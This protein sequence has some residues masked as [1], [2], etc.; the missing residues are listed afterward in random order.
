MLVLDLLPDHLAQGIEVLHR[1]PPERHGRIALRVV[2]ALPIEVRLDPSDEVGDLRPLVLGF[3]EQEPQELLP[4][5][6]PHRPVVRRHPPRTPLDLRHRLIARVRPHRRP[7]PHALERSHVESEPTVVLAIGLLELGVGRIEPHEVL[8]LHVEHD[9]LGV[10][11]VPPEHVR[12]EQG[13]EEEQ[14]VGRLGRDAGDAGDVHVGAAGP[15]EEVEV[16]EHRLA[17]PGQACRE[18]P[19]HL[20]EV[21]GLVPVLAPGPGRGQAWHGRDEHL[22]L[23]PGGHDLG[24]DRRVDRQ[25]AALNEEHVRVELRS[26]VP[27]PDVLD[28]AGDPKRT[29]PRDLRVDYAGVVAL[30]VGIGGDAHPENERGGVLGTQD[31]ADRLADVLHHAQAASSA[32]RA[33]RAR[34][35][36]P[37]WPNRC[38]RNR[39]SPA[40]GARFWGN[41][42][43]KGRPANPGSRAL[44]R[45]ARL[46]A[47]PRPLATRTPQPTRPAWSCHSGRL[48]TRRVYH[49]YRSSG[50]PS[51]TSPNSGV[52]SP[53]ESRGRSASS[54]GSRY[55]RT[56]RFTTPTTGLRVASRNP[57]RPSV[58]TSSSL[59]AAMREASAASCAIIA[60]CRP[61]SGA[62]GSPPGSVAGWYTRTAPPTRTSTRRTPSTNHTVPGSTP[63]ETMGTLHSS[64]STK[65]S[66]LAGVSS[67]RA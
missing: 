58:S 32:R 28:D 48:R 17:V 43:S 37:R 29:P 45:S 67:S 27:G 31:P 26:L 7:H 5:E 16:E 47:P 44:T 15:V 3:G 40:I 57:R 56:N 2:G 61:N 62:S 49:A 35:I 53:G 36:S 13:V 11:R 21:Q 39:S 66:A 60:F 1:V 6:L 64:V 55:A 46:L 18:P 63:R 33:I 25:H 4:D 30:E 12:V 10:G 20:V 9:G 23:E 42:G 38:R 59:P 22:G 14:R 41:R 19:L 65:G 50:W 51:Y 54:S 24:G 8:A 34:R 52:R